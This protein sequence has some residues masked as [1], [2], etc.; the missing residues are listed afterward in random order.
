MGMYAMYD[1]I[2]DA[3]GGWNYRGRVEATRTVR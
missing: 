2:R 1:D 3:L